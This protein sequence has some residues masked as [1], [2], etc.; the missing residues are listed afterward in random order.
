MTWNLKLLHISQLLTTATSASGTRHHNRQ[1]YL[2]RAL[3]VL[4]SLCFAFIVYVNLSPR[5]EKRWVM[6]KFT[7]IKSTGVTRHWAAHVVIPFCPVNSYHW[8][9]LRQVNAC[10]MQGSGRTTISSEAVAC[11]YKTDRINV[12]VLRIAVGSSKCTKIFALSRMCFLFSSK[13]SVKQDWDS[14]R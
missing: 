6:N 3:Q 13:P 9:D 8:W 11:K 10:V 12:H 2:P 5:N 14:K 4:Y 1:K 7:T